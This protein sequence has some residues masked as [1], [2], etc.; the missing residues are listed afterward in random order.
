MVNKL[1]ATAMQVQEIDEQAIK[2][3]EKR[4]YE[5]RLARV[6]ALGTAL[7]GKRSEAVEAR[8]QS[9]VEEDWME[10][11]EHYEGIDDANRDFYRNNTKP[12]SP[13]GGTEKLKDT[14][15]RSRVFL[16]ITR[17]Y[18]DAAAA[19]V[20]D[21]LLPTDDQNWGIDP[22]PIPTLTKHKENNAPLIKPDGSPMMGESP[23]GQKQMTVADHVKKIMDMAKDSAKQAETRIDDW[24][25]ECNFNHETRKVIEKCARLGTGVIKGPS[26]VARNYTSLSKANGLTSL[27]KKMK[28]SPASR[29]IDPW[30]LFPDASCGNDIHS[31][32]YIFERDRLTRRKV[33]ELLDDDTYIPEMVNRALTEGPQK[34]NIDDKASERNGLNIDTNSQFEVWYFTGYISREDLEAAGCP[35]EEG[36]DSIAAVIVMINDYVVKAAL[37][38]LD[39]G[40]F[41][42]DVMTWQERDGHW[43]GIGVARQIRT[44][45]RI[46]NSG[47]RNIMDNAGLM[48]GPQIVMKRSMIEPAD[49]N[50]ALTPRK[51]WYMLEDAAGTVQEAF[52]A[53]NIPAMQEQLF[54]IVQYATKMAEDVTGLPAL[55]QGQQGAAPE[56][57][58]G[59]Q[60]LNNNASTVMRRIARTYDDKITE[61]HIRRYYEWLLLDSDVPDSEKGD[62]K[63]VAR[64]SSALVE[65]DIQNQTIAQMGNMVA[66]PAFGIDPKRWAGEYF[67]SQRL[68]PRTFQF[69]E[70]ELKAQAEAMAKN[71]PQDPRQITA[72][73]N[74]EATKIRTDGMVAVSQADVKE[75]QTQRELD[76]QDAREERASRERLA[77]MQYETKIMEL[78][79]KRNL[80]IQQIK[81]Q[82]A[83]VAI[84]EKNKRDLQRN[85]IEVKAST[86]SGL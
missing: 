17:P 23:E 15:V 27:V 7:T 14:T 52:A 43:A 54:S 26:P 34:K 1:K 8:R 44:P 5:E 18:V 62:F 81:A 71:P 67:K 57:V 30:D 49:G 59:M 11:E 66:N 29:C 36:Q 24:L 42:Y 55:L 45:Q 25:T 63:I 19:K 32:S 86:G 4:I 48:S 56:T 79:D 77:T 75:K 85:E 9:G 69:T 39:S 2:A 51:I 72:Q 58:G 12:T 60:M 10:D 37:N 40:E 61:P 38:P 80:S 21:M 16:N 82:L 35:C 6:Q 73:A 28:L 33:E 46:L 76:L 31:G 70:E 65:R 50:W 47:V 41:P 74:I 78:A 83:T 64:G 53:I 13:D 68:D 20:A 3:E 84:T 22:T